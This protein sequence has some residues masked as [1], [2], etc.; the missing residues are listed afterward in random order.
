MYMLEK[1][2]GEIPVRARRRK[3]QSGLFS[4]LCR[5]ERTSHWDIPEK[6]KHNRAKSKYF[7]SNCLLIKS[8]APIKK[9][10]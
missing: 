6:V 3:A 10:K 2:T 7:S 4:T 8:R 1:E 9:E 5:K